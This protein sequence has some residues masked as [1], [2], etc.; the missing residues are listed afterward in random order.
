M[1]MAVKIPSIGTRVGDGSGNGTNV[2]NQGTF[3]PDAY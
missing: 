3:P 1:V 2:L